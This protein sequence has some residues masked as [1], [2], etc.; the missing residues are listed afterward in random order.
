VP[1]E[2][3]PDIHLESPLAAAKREFNLEALKAI[4]KEKGIPLEKLVAQ[5]VENLLKED[6]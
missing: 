3:K 1:D 4:A 5:A 6:K 2:K